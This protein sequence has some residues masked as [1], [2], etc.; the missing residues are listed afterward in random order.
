MNKAR[1]A[2][3]AAFGPER[4]LSFPETNREPGSELAKRGD[5][6]GDSP[7]CRGEP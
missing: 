1:R 3:F 5:G 2:R 4:L 7:R 6:N